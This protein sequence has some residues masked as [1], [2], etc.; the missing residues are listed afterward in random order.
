MAEKEK[1]GVDTDLIRHAIAGHVH[2]R[3]TPKN[4]ARESRRTCVLSLPTFRD[5]KNRIAYRKARP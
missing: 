3:N 4:A 5:Y 1:V 2:T